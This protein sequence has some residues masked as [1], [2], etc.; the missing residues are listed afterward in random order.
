M[1]T[2]IFDIETVGEE[3]NDL[4]ETSH[5]VLTRWIDKTAKN[6]EERDAQIDDLKNGLGFSP[7][8]GFVV[9]IGLYDL[10]RK[11]GVVF[12]DPHGEDHNES[13]H[14]GYILKPRTEKEMLQ[15]FWE[16]ARKYDTFVTFNGRAFDA[17][18]LALR[19]AICGITPSRD[20]L[21]GRYTYQQRS[22][23]H[24][25]LADQLSFYGAM[26]R[27]SSLHMFCRAF[28]IQS[29]KEA[30]VT[31]DDV[32][33]LFKERRTID[34]ARYNVRDVIATTELYERW[35]THLSFQKS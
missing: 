34:I 13:E 25:D 23:K 33:A 29:P 2:L 31:G 19:S 24:I 16:G 27:K 1:S 9:A 4:D 7:L 10:E 17:P 32:S 11:K 35:K 30:G 18:F 21:E 26:Y 22:C 5:E 15:D 12:Y 20:L 28:G 6:E 3:W 8:T 14:G